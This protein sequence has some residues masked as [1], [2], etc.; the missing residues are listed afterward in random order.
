M[1]MA[2]PEV[3]RL[4]N[5]KI[6]FSQSIQPCCSK[7]VVSRPPMTTRDQRRADLMKLYAQR[8]EEGRDIFNGILL[9]PSERLLE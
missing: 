7:D 8:Y 2:V 1:N 3:N 4:Y 6:R 9:P 5:K